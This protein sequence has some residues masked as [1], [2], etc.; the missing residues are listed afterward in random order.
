M[1]LYGYILDIII[2]LANIKLLKLLRFN[3]KINALGLTLSYIAS[4]LLSFLLALLIVFIA[5]AQLSYVVFARVLLSFSTFLASC[6]TLFT[7]MLSKW[8][9]ALCSQYWC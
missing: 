5:F 8:L 7:L 6:E 1:Q 9:L 4:P 3:K 2:F